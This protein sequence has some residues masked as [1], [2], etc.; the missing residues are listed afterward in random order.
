MF[1][2]I[3]KFFQKIFKRNKKKRTIFEHFIYA[4]FKKNYNTII[5]T[6]HVR[7]NDYYD[8]LL[9]QNDKMRRDW[10]NIQ[11]CFWVKEMLNFINSHKKSD[12]LIKCLTGMGLNLNENLDEIINYNI[13]YYIHQDPIFLMTHLIGTYSDEF[14]SQ[15]E[16]MQI[17]LQ[18]I[19]YAKKRD[20][21]L[22]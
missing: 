22:Q 1:Q 2:T 20:K 14:L 4:F 16:K 12:R 15:S 9:S 19:K 17:H 7:Y 5:N 8:N 6:K 13:R 18:W 21:I 10:N 3:I 11:L